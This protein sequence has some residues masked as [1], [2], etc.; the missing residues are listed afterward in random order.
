MPSRLGELSHLRTL[1]MYIVNPARGCGI[2]ELKELNLG[3]RLDLYDLAKIGNP[4]DARQSGLISKRN[5]SRLLLSWGREIEPYPIESDPDTDNEILHGLEPH[6]GLEILQISRYNGTRFAEWMHNSRV[7]RNLIELKLRW[8]RKCMAIPPLWQLPSLERLSLYQL[9]SLK[10]IC[11]GSPLLTH[12]GSQGLQI[13][14]KLELLHLAYL[15]SLESWIENDPVEI[16]SISF[17]QLLDLVIR[18]CPQ[19]DVLPSC[20]MLRVLEITGENKIPSSDIETFRNK[21]VECKL[22]TV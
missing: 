20:P 6:R 22:P 3:G 1:T 13:F 18:D 8:C 12:D 14:P 21:G 9:H 10:H 4:P 11:I 16:T 15:P 2:E 5:L 17:P 7:L 19:L